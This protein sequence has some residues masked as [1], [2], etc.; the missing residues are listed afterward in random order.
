MDPS[1]RSEPA[2]RS[3][4][5]ANPPLDGEADWSRVVRRIRRD[6]F[7]IA[8]TP[9]AALAIVVAALAAWIT[10]DNGKRI[11][12]VPANPVPTSPS[13]TVVTTAAGDPSGCA[14][15]RDVPF[16]LTYLP[17]D[18]PLPG[19]P[20]QFGDHPAFWVFPGGEIE[21]WRG[22]DIPQ[23][24]EPTELITVLGHQGRLGA[25]SDGY[26]VVFNLGDPSDIC[27]QWALVSHPG[28]SLDETRAIATGLVPA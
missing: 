2:S 25:I 11:V 16:K 18:A 13:P 10:H 23:P 28:T 12:V 5:E 22:A 8:L 20:L 7:R 9:L 4:S 21:M 26:S 24:S 15:L 6:R 1:S 27:T 3:T 14:F 17:R 19:Q